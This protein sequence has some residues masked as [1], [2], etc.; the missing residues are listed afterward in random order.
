MFGNY[1]VV[2]ST[3]GRAQLSLTLRNTRSVQELI[4]NKNVQNRWVKHKSMVS[5]YFFTTFTE[6]MSY[7]LL[8]SPREHTEQSSIKM[9]LIQTRSIAFREDAKFCSQSSLLS[10]CQDYAK[11]HK[12]EVLNC[13]SGWQYYNSVFFSATGCLSI[14]SSPHILNKKSP[15]V[16]VNSLFLLSNIK[17]LEQVNFKIRCAILDRVIRAF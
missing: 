16:S 12:F 3:K 14:G 11:I 4:S 2:T 1:H 13:S 10:T 5:L 17:F 7:G 6:L 8:N 9:A 15:F